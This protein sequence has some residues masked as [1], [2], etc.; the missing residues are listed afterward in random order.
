[1]NYDPTEIESVC[2]KAM[3]KTR[4][5]MNRD[6]YAGKRPR[7]KYF[8]PGQVYDQEDLAQVRAIIKAFGDFFP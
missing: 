7:P 1:M 4:D 6:R 5:K 3:R 8:G 2:I